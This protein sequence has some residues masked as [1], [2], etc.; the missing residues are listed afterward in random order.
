MIALL[1]LLMAA[2]PVERL[3][4]DEIAG[5]D[6]KLV[7]LD[8]QV[9]ELENQVLELESKV[10]A[11]EAMK[12]Q[13]VAALEAHREEA[14]ARLARLYRMRQRGLATVLLAAETPLDFRRRFRYLTA[15]VQADQARSE[16]YLA[17]FKDLEKL[18][19]QLS[20]DMQTLAER[21]EELAKTREE[22]IEQRAGRV[23]LL[24]E[25]RSS[26]HLS[27]TYEKQAEEARSN[28]QPVQVE[29]VSEKTDF[30]SLRGKLP[31]PIKAPVLRGFGE[32]VD[33]ASGGK[34]QNL[35]VDFVTKVG[36]PFMAVAD[37]VVTQVRYVKAY[38]QTIE[39]E[40]GSYATIYSHANGVK[41]ASGD[42]VVA[43][44]VI[45]LAGNSG[46]TD[47]SNGY[48]HFEVRYN[49]SAQDPLVWLSPVSCHPDAVRCP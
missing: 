6:L 28:Y 24:K 46:L 37:G 34:R 15:I 19:Q 39:I 4:L 13:A 44:Q 35:G 23:R 33:V 27:R 2:S 18:E 45:G 26:E 21:K 31:I 12:Q 11:Q 3:L 20:V 16:R 43:R 42:T 48:L 49:G 25:I 5:Y 38:G 17:A 22:L 47:D 14:E 10:K 1:W 32:L 40:H 8:E 36:T 41:V 29:A 30:R 7:T 9:G